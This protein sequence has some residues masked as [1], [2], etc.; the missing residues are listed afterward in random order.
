M[1]RKLEI[2]IKNL[3]IIHK[4]IM[5]R[6]SIFLSC[7]EQNCLTLRFHYLLEDMK[8]K[9]FHEWMRYHFQK[10]SCSGPEISSHC[11]ECLYVKRILT[12]SFVCIC[13]WTHV[14]LFYTLFTLVFIWDTKLHTVKVVLWWCAKNKL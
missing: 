9:G 1:N 8:M 4:F 13:K 7:H 11:R 3:F 10:D 2:L 6:I 14:F 5:R 12:I